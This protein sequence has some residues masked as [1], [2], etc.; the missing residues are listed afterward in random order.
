MNVSALNVVDGVDVVWRS[1][2]RLGAPMTGKLAELREIYTSIAAA[3]AD[4]V[5]TMTA[6]PAT[7]LIAVSAHLQRRSFVYATASDSDFE[8]ERAGGRASRTS[9]LF[10]LAVRLA[11]FV[12]VYRTSASAVCAKRDSDVRLW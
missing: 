10:G 5:V 1:P 12:V 8:G 2:Y 4:V 7:A 11:D 3:D 9:R 6:V